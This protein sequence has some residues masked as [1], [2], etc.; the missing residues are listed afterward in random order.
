MVW[1]KTPGKFVAQISAQFGLGGEICA[2]L[3]HHF[4]VALSCQ[5]LPHVPVILFDEV[6]ERRGSAW[7]GGHQ[8]DQLTR[9]EGTHE[10]LRVQR[11]GVTA[12]PEKTAVLTGEHVMLKIDLN[13]KK[14]KQVQ[15]TCSG[16]GCTG[17]GICT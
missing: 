13:K 4:G 14:K 6:G 8:Q 1:H 3:S 5:L 16:S 9:A 12:D 15:L 2:Q 17:T 11:L 7:L 10:P